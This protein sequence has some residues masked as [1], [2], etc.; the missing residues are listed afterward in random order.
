MELTPTGTTLQGEDSG[1]GP[2][3]VLLHGL[4]ATRR[5]VLSGSRALERSGHR[6]VAYDARGHGESDAAASYGYS[7]QTADLGGLIAELGLERP[8]L[9]GQSM[10]AAT[11]LAF[12]LGAPEQVGALVQI[13]PAYAGE[14]QPDPRWERLAD[15]LERD[16]VDGFM[17][18]YEPT[19]DPKYRDVV[20]TFT[21][22]RLGRHRH[23]DAV[24]QALREV[25]RSAAFDGLERLAG[26]EVP[27][28]IVATRDDADP[29]HPLAVAERYA[30]LLPRAR[31]YVD[32]PGQSPLAW[33]G[34][35]LS[36]AIASWLGEED[37][38]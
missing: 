24:A 21:R 5:Y 29:E 11:A 12:A 8:V 14:P 10:G 7:E 38:A 32:P 28:L 35:R 17:D 25:P 31:L 4:T 1:T 30:E 26:L 19:T 23:P 37:G 2:P 3:V 34:V 20:E 9:V 16:G 13:T 27:T 33:Q 36:K 6:V 18:A 15:G 22:Q